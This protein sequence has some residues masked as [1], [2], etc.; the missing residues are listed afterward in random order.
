MLDS[1]KHWNGRSQMTRGARINRVG[2][3]DRAKLL[4]QAP[5]EWQIA[6]VSGD[7]DGLQF[8]QLETMRNQKR[9]RSS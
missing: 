7:T 4:H 8:L 2:R 1:Q 5:Q 3:Y 9:K 6:N